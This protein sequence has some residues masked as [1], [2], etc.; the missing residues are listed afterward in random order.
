MAATGPNNWTK[1]KKG[2][3]PTL[4]GSNAPTAAPAHSLAP[5]AQPAPVSP[6]V[7]DT[8]EAFRRA[9]PPVVDLSKADQQGKAVYL[10]AITHAIDTSDNKNDQARYERGRDWL[11]RGDASDG[12]GTELTYRELAQ[13]LEKQ[14]VNSPEAARL[15]TLPNGPIHGRAA[16]PYF[17][18]QAEKLARTRYSGARSSIAST[19]ALTTSGGWFGTFTPARGRIEK[20]RIDPKDW[21]VI[22]RHSHAGRDN[23]RNSGVLG[24]SRTP[25]P[26]QL[27]LLATS[28]GV[29]RWM[30]LTE[31]DDHGHWKST[32]A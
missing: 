31:Q 12:D 25:L 18:V 21:R 28:K 3:Q 26:G 2:F 17:Q 6:P 5:S 4:T 10:A 23:Y 22:P 27:I 11:V 32:H 13:L 7:G 9:T 24:R 1:G 14:D 20:T 16:G 15:R 29:F 30:R 8:Y 19:A